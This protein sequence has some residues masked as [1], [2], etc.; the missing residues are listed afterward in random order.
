[1]DNIDYNYY[2]EEC[3]NFLVKLVKTPSVN[4]RENESK[5][6]ELIGQEADKLGLPSKIIAKEASR[7]NIFSEIH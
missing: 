7:P 5:V 4:G 2:T 1:M 3:I 6:V